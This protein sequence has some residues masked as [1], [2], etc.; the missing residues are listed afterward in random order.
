MVI[1]VLSKMDG[2][3]LLMIVKRYFVCQDFWW[4][5]LTTCHW[6]GPRHNEWWDVGPVLRDKQGSIRD[7]FKQVDC[8]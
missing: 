5:N 7:L 3:F 4:V 2:D 1:D 6:S 8:S